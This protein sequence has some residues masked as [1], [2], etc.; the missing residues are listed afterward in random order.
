MN[1]PL[2]LC[3]VVGV[4]ANGPLQV[5][6]K[7]LPKQN[8]YVY[9]PTDNSQKYPLLSFAHGVGTGSGLLPAEY[10]GTMK[11]VASW[12]YIIIALEGDIVALQEFKDQVK[13][14]SYMLNTPPEDLKDI[15]DFSAPTGVY[16]HSMGGASTLNAASDKP[17]IEETRIAAA[18]A[19]HP[20]IQLGSLVPHVPTLYFTGS[21]DPLCG[22]LVTKPQYE[23]ANAENITRGYVVMAGYDHLRVMGPESN[24]EIDGIAAWFDCFVKKDSQKCNTIFNTNPADCSKTF[25]SQHTSHCEVHLGKNT[26]EVSR[27]D[28][29]VLV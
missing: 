23:L 18:V 6:M 11:G 29:V 8:A 3:M 25:P 16:G 4:A 5:A 20:G 14:L 19:M 2:Q 13:C 21:I 17:S 28:E 24:G 26:T 9:Y 10:G 1:L 22:P 12:G 27:N 15:I 7:H